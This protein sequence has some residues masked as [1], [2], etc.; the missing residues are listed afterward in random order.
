MKTRRKGNAPKLTALDEWRLSRITLTNRRM[1]LMKILS[2]FNASNDISICKR[3]F[4]RYCGHLGFT[5]SPSGKK[6]IHKGTSP[7]G[8][9][10]MVQTSEI[11]GP[12]VTTGQILSSVTRVWLKLKTIIASLEKTRRR[13]QTRAL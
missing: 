5:R 9:T 11:F 1:P 2:A 10:G 4:D 13:V 8:Q 7:E 12:S 6:T 3:T